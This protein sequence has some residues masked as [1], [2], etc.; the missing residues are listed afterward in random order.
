MLKAITNKLPYKVRP[1]KIIQSWKS[2]YHPNPKY[3]LTDLPGDINFVKS[4]VFDCK[5][6]VDPGRRG[7][8]RMKMFYTEATN[9][10]EIQVVVA[11]F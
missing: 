6:F 9:K 11:Q 7:D 5:R 8:V 2:I 10:A 1:W 4:Y 3:L